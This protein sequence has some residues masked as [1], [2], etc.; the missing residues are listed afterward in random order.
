MKFNTRTV[1][2][3]LACVLCSGC[4]DD[5]QDY[6]GRDVREVV[7][8]L[9]DE[10]RMIIY[11]RNPSDIFEKCESVD[12]VVLYPLN[13]AW[14]SIRISSDNNCRVTKVEKYFSTHK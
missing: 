9:D 6:T 14:L 4:A 13:D 11:P 12:Q 8:D 5:R 1:S 2:I 10:D 7:R 3:A